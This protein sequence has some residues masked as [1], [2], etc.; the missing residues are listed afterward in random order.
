MLYVTTRIKHDTFTAYQALNND[1]GPGGGFYVPMR[2]PQFSETEI[3]AMGEKSFS[4]NTAEIV[5]HLFGTKLDGWA[6]EFA[7][8]RYPVKIVSGGSR[9]LI[10]ESW[11]NPAWRFERLARGI[12]KAIRQ[13]DQICPVPSD[14]LMTG[15]RIAVLFGIFGE[16]L[17]SG[18]VSFERPLDLAVPTGNFS[19]P[20][21][22][23]YGR[24]MGLPIG[25]ILCC[26]NENGGAWSL[27]HKGYLRTDAAISR[28]DTPLCDHAAPADL[29]RLIFATLGIEEAV[30]F[31]ES[32]RVR[33][34]YYL[35]P[36]DL[37]TL[38]Q[39]VFATVVSKSQ[40]EATVTG[41]YGSVGY[42]ADPYTALCYGGIGAYRS[43]TG[44]SRTALILSEE[45]PVH[46]IDLLARCLG[47][48]AEELK[49]AID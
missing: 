2:L 41:L 48:T 10:A 20:M 12:E 29:E 38:R 22:C 26:C 47:T 4:Q 44:E 6:I 43:R 14:W 30:D 49:K 46:H 39:G 8:G 35:E 11:H 19:G 28:T 1:R 37:Q 16:L 42:V 5:N 45:S 23:W 17:H 13:S 15:S 18:D 33:S 34:T 9:I 21:A 24:S 32:C 31:S 40:M 3:L 36:S 27:I 7:I 25:N